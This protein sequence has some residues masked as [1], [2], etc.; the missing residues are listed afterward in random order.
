MITHKELLER[1][2]YNPETGIFKRKIPTRGFRKGSVAGWHGERYVEIRL[3]DRSYLAHRL[4]WFYVH[5]VFPEYQIDHVDGDKTNNRITNLREATGSEN[6]M[7]YGATIRSTTGHRGVFKSGKSTWR[8]RAMLYGKRIDLGS[9]DSI[10]RANQAYLEFAKK[11]HK[12]FFY[13]KQ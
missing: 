1:L 9:F 3:L 6:L 8:A 5:G 13:A 4:A 11:N 7:N 12:E 2:E 10:D